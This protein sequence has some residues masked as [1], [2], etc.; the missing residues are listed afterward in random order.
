M[1][2]GGAQSSLSLHRLL[3][4]PVACVRR[5]L[6]SAD[7]G[8]AAG[9]SMGPG[10][11]DGVMGLGLRAGEGEVASGEN[12][13]WDGTQMV[14]GEL[15]GPSGLKRLERPLGKIGLPEGLVGLAGTIDP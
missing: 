11:M 8:L 13:M 1:G 10:S 3:P 6:F 7:S 12:W 5:S 14:P 15:A 9:L 4:L 2:L